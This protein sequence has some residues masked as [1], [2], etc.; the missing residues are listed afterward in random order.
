VLV[1][2]PAGYGKSTLVSCW[3]EVCEVPHAWVTLDEHDD[4]FQRFVTYLI[5]AVQSIFPGACANM[6]S[7]L[8]SEHL[9]VAS[10]LANRLVDELDRI[11]Q[12]F[13]LTLDD[14][15]LIRNSHI[16]ELVA[17]L[18]RHPS[19][20]MQLVLI[21]RRDP[22]L[23][24]AL[25]RAKGRMIEIRTRDLRFSKAET[26]AYL[27]QMAGAHV[28]GDIAAV[29]AERTEGWVTGLHLAAL[30]MRDNRDFKRVLTELP[31]E[32]RY[33]MDY[34]VAEILSQQPPDVQ[35]WMMRASIPSRFCASLCDAMGCPDPD[36][37]AATLNGHGFLDLLQDADLF[38]IPLDNEG[39]WF[40]FHHLFQTLLKRQLKQRCSAA[41]IAALHQR[42]SAW[43]H[44]NGQTEEAL[45]HAHASGDFATAARLLRQYRHD[46]LMNF[47]QWFQL[48]RLVNAFP[49]DIVEQYPDLLLA[50]AWVYHRQA[51][52]ADLFAI[53]DRLDSIQPMGDRPTVAERLFLAEVLALKS[54]Q[55]YTASRGGLSA[56]AAREALNLLPPGY[57]GLRGFALMILSAALQ[58]Q[59]QPLQARQVLIDGMRHEMISAPVY[60]SMVLSALCFTDWI[61]SDLK[62]LQETAYQLLKHGQ[63]HDLPETIATGGYFSGICHYQRNDLYLAERFLS[64]VA[65]FSGAGEVNIP[66]VT[67]YCQ[68]GL[69]LAATYQALGR[70]K[71]AGEVV[72]SVTGYMLEIDN[73]DLL[74]LCH[75]FGADLALRQGEVA[76]AELWAG[77]HTPSPLAPVYRFYSPH[78][79]R[80]RV[81]LARR[82][83]HSLHEAEALLARMAD[84]YTSIHSPRMLIDI[85]V[86]Q[87]L[88]LDA[89]A[90]EPQALEKLAAALALAEPGGFIR[91]F[92]DQGAEAANL[93]GLLLLQNPTQPYAR[94]VLEAFGSEKT[95]SSGN[96][97]EDHG[98]SRS[99][100]QGDPLI[101]PLSAREIEALKFLAR[102]V[103]NKAIADALFIS[104]ETVKRHLSTIYRKL[105]VKNR[106]EAVV[107][108]KSLGIL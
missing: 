70:V 18:L 32:N 61:A 17:S 82:T 101:Q 50:K 65:G 29:L 98:Q 100:S 107:V 106:H 37:G 90:N 83:A 45:A 49:P 75:A 85:F 73:P 11:E 86:L 40:R 54:L 19:T 10:E 33:V 34:M 12:A 28:D 22:A 38:V 67:M 8:M 25:L 43:F 87:A 21:G 23:P 16:H 58:M 62:S 80:P 48:I 7:V 102:G 81:L 36:T 63:Q 91:P 44:E 64:P 9:P 15:H 95:A 31:A 41:E 89:K 69:A 79:T 4:D 88:V 94:Q 53:L 57:P 27:S 108:A 55:Y 71:E 2:A 26:E 77:K 105:D 74:E 93:L 68:S 66:N 1:S 3:L 24:L 39:E 46:A 99:S 59:G 30:S 35:V 104:L 72:E 52:Y 96:R 20:C 6:Q 42:A 84:Y 51:R 13:I 97:S 92:L 14:Y 56:T 78:L 5:A 76:A 103:S 60:K 47:G